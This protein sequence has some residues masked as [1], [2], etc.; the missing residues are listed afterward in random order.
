[1]KQDVEK[2]KIIINV[3]RLVKE[4]GQMHLI[5]A[6]AKLE[7]SNNWKLVLL[8]DGYLRKDIEEI[9]QELKIEDRVFLA[10]AVKN[11]DEWLN[12][13]SL[14][15]FPSISEGFPNALLEAMAIGLPVIS[16]DCDAG[17]R[18]IIENNLNGIL[19]NLG[20][21][22]DLYQQINSLIN[23]EGKRK[24][25]GEEAL[26]VKYKYDLKNIANQYLEFC[27]K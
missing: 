7:A 2:E 19:V 9:I 12:R 13:A 16:F 11:V 3:G 10:G 20:D 25:L 14:F 15:V 5:R 18:D 6:F 23:D 21:E 1:M 8:G 22:E 27:T 26:Q 4:K 24:K 17:P